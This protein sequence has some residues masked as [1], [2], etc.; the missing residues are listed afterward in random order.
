MARVISMDVDV[1]ALIRKKRME[2]GLNQTKLGELMFGSDQKLESKRCTVNAL[3][4][5]S[6][7][8]SVN[9]LQMIANALGLKL[10]IDMVP[11]RSEE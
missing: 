10:V 8:P 1:H 11:T 4:S 3:E 7:V 5:G 6:K 9:Q 2:A